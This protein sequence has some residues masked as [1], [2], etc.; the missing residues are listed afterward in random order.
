MN[1][2]RESWSSYARRIFDEVDP[3]DVLMWG[4]I[5]AWWVGLLL[6]VLGTWSP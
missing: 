2:R 5:V 4:G 3:L 1:R 6:I